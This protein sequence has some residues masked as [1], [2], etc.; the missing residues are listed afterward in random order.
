MAQM[1]SQVRPALRS[2]MSA[3]ARGSASYHDGISFNAETGQV[4]LKAPGQAPQV[5]PFTTAF[6]FTRGSNALY[7]GKSGLLLTASS[8]VPV[9]E[10][11]PTG[12]F[13]G[14]RTEWAATNVA[15]NNADLSN[16]SWTKSNC[17]IG[18]AVT[19]VDGTS[20]NIRIVEDNTTSIHG[21]IAGMTITANTTY[22]MS[23]IVSPQGRQFG[24]M[25]GINT[26]Q[27][28]AIFDFVNLTTAPI[29]AGTSTI[30]QRGILP[31]G[32][33]RYLIWVSGVL[34][35]ASTTLNFVGGPAVSLSVPSG[36]TYLGDGASGITMEYI[37]V[38][39]ADSPSSRI[40]TAG[41]A[42]VR[43]EDQA[44]RN[45]GSEYVAGAN[46]VIAKGRASPGQRPT[47]QTVWYMFNG[48]DNVFVGRA[49]ASDFP[50]FNAFTTSV[51]QGPADSGTFVNNAPFKTAAAWSASNDMA[52]SFNGAAVSTDT[53]ATIV[54]MLTLAFGVTG[55]AQNGHL[56]QF[57]MYN[58]RIPN[59]RLPLLSAL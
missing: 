51:A 41:S 48:A 9:Y 30:N 24:Y 52:H 6:S 55:S 58:T 31:W 2:G 47:L 3:L 16:A 40:L 22:C 10:Y 12:D 53:V 11:G 7:R 25:Y 42:G 8:N 36:Y 13:Y 33:G 1:A 44:L 46:T 57:D 29:L 32:D 18:A 59:E 14:F 35:A 34:N 50:R 45:F 54:S 26:D 19:S 39:A 38:E 21:V 27:F 43:S 4:V 17:T 37:Q 20:R 23:A 15:L 56:S 5:V 28:G 49:G